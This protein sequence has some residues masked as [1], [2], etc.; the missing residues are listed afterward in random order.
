MTT[1]VLPFTRAQAEHA[2]DV[3]A[4]LHEDGPLVVE[5]VNVGL[6]L[7]EAICPACS[8]AFWVSDAAHSWGTCPD[9]LKEAIVRLP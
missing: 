6:D 3:T 7:A 9:C 4:R 2:R 8:L 5:G 1:T